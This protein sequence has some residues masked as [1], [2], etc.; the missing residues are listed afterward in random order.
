MKHGTNF[1]SISYLDEMCKSFKRLRELY[2][3]HL[4]TNSYERENISPRNQD[5]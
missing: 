2:N 5:T 4:R 1:P 3:E